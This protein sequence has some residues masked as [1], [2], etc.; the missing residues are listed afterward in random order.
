M[1]LC[2]DSTKSV[3]IEQHSSSIYEWRASEYIRLTDMT[4]YGSE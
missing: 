1:R 2:D 3:G 4:Q